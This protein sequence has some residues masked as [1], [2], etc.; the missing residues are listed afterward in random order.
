[1]IRTFKISDSILQG[2]E[3]IIPDLTNDSD[4]QICVIYVINELKT[5]L[6]NL[7]MTNMVEYVGKQDWHIHEEWH[8]ILDNPDRIFWVCNHY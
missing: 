2:F 8:E 3:V 7:R 6:K 4:K 5:V 1:M